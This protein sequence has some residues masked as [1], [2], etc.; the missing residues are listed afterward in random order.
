L[1]TT[2]TAVELSLADAATENSEWPNWPTIFR[3]PKTF[4]GRHH[5]RQRTLLRHGA[6]GNGSA[7]AIF[8]GFRLLQCEK[9]QSAW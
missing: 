4:E 7:E 3:S 1:S 5:R 6:T 2:F 9:T 8:W